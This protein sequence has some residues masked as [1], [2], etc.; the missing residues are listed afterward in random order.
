M[1]ATGRMPDP[2]IY[3]LSRT[4]KITVRAE[5]YGGEG[6]LPEGLRVLVKLDSTFDAEQKARLI[7]AAGKC[8]VKRMLSGQLKQG[9]T[10]AYEEGS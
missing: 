1:S 2:P 6:H 7:A 10:T 5:E 4:A 8:P 3:P 9:I